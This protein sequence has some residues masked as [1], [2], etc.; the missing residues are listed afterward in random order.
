MVGRSPVRE[1]RKEL[2]GR[3]RG[4]GQESRK[5][6][7]GRE[8]KKRKKK[9]VKRK[10]RRKKERKRRERSKIP[11]TSQGTELNNFLLYTS[12]CRP[13][14]LLKLTMWS[15]VL[16]KVSML[17]TMAA[18]PEENRSEPAAPSIRASVSAAASTVGL[19][20]RLYR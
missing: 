2:R 6:N 10:G 1:E 5:R 4:G 19:P 11:R 17:V 7:E 14:M 18:I 20:Q 12:F 13:W 16:R 15:P 3:R 8:K 9:R